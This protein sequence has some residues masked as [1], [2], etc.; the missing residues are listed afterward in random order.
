MEKIYFV[1]NRKKKIWWGPYYSFPEAQQQIKRYCDID[2]TYCLSEDVF[3]ITAI[4]L[5][6]TYNVKY[7]KE[8]SRVETLEST[9]FTTESAANVEKLA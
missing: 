3:E 9:R 5:T 1:L 7:H 6:E 4:P 2:A 8:G